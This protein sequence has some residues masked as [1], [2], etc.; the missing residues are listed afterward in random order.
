MFWT[1]A[2]YRPTTKFRLPSL[3]SRSQQDE[4]VVSFARHAGEGGSVLYGLSRNRRLRTW[5]VETGTCLRTLDVRPS[6]STE[7]VQ[8]NESTPPRNASS[9]TSLLE[10]V[11]QIKVIRHPSSSSR[12]SHLVIA[13]YPTPHSPSSAGSFV[14]YR[15]SDSTGSTDLIQAG[16]RSCSSA[17]AGA[18]MRGFEVLPP[19]VREGMNTGWRMQVAWES[20]GGLQV[21]TV[22]MDD[23]FQFT[24]TYLD[25]PSSFLLTEWQQA[26]EC[27]DADQFDAAY[28]DNLL[29]PDAPDPANPNENSDITITFIDHLFYPGR[30]S[31]LT[32]SA[33]LEEYIQSLSR[34]GVT[35]I[36]TTAN[37][38]PTLQ[39]RFASI[40]GCH[41]QVE[42]DL[43]TG[44]PVVEAYRNDLKLDWLGIWAR[45][46]DLDKQGR[47]AVH[48][49]VVDR[50]V[51]VLT[52]EG[53]SSTAVQ[54]VTGVIAKFAKSSETVADFR[55]LPEGA[56][57]HLYPG[58]AAPKARS[59]AVA[60]SSAGAFIA[61]TLSG[62]SAEDG[63]ANALEDV[64]FAMKSMFAGGIQQPIEMLAGEMWDEAIEPYL[65]DED[66]TTIRRLLSECL[67]VRR[68]LRE[69]LAMLTRTLSLPSTAPSL[70]DSFSG[71][72]NALITAS[73][74]ATISDRYTASLDTL[75]VALFHL[76]ESADVTAEDDEAE[77]F[78]EILN[79]AFV[80]YHRYAVLKW[81]TGQTAD[82]AVEVSRQ[83]GST[84]RKAAAGDDVLAEGLGGL[85]VGDDEGANDG[86]DASYSLLHSLLDGQRRQPVPLG[87]I[88]VVAQAAEL[89]VAT[90]GL[91]SDD[92]TEVDP[93][94]LD[95]GF[96]YSILATGLPLLAGRFAD[97]YP[98]S[99]GMAYIR[100]RASM[101]AGFVGQ[102][103]RSFEQASVGCKGK[104]A[105]LV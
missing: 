59:G 34:H 52:R 18:E 22:A 49:A 89:L 71:F 70:S 21:E 25:H 96:G 64:T 8:Y 41:L 31:I 99:A 14:V 66:R 91:V 46:R 65:S 80:V 73:I 23:I 75:F 54:D 32:L 37:G 55:A 105:P 29:G 63:L 81:A 26:S 7:L 68:A 56:M 51:Y 43:Q 85:Q 2:H 102:A 1:A 97:L 10:G 82:E 95:V 84:K 39:R 98:L 79:Q 35:H 50:Q 13:Y 28:F 48:T 40:V 6:T 20:K 62:A 4:E 101:E 36:V 77:D 60:L 92:I 47:W 53:V 5:H 58:L 103:V 11:A 24:T 27:T 78:I 90:S 3:F 67:D 88:D 94:T 42:M 86:F 83:K 9:S 93:S 69:A 61:S 74:A 16:A 76:S 104:H 57:R 17:S 15:G 72:G 30:F 87:S 12:Y 100:G 45:V 19:Y 33:A 44:A 38:L